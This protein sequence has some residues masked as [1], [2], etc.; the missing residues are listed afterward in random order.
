MKMMARSPLHQ[1][2]FP[3]APSHH[4]RNLGLDWNRTTDTRIF[5]S[6][7]PSSFLLFS[8]TY[9]VDEKFCVCAVIF[10]NAVK[11]YLDSI[12]TMPLNLFGIPPI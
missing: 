6:D 8:K 3:N 5:N 1:E 7:R 4:N 11:K 9:S 12:S 10:F 2:S